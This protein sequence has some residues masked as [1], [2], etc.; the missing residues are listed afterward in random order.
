[1]EITKPTLLVDEAI[2][3]QNIRTMQAKA[4]Q[5][6]ALLRPHFKTHQSKEVGEWFRE[7]GVDAITVSS[8]SMARYFSDCGWTDIT[9][10]FPHNPLEWSEIHDLAGSIR[11]NVTIVS[12]EALDH[13]KA[14]VKNPLH[15]WIKI[16]VG[17]HRT[18]VLPENVELVR[19]LAGSGGQHQ[20]EG[21]LA[22]A[23]HSYTQLDRE[24]A[25]SIFKSSIDLMSSLKAGLGVETKLSYGDTPTCSL[26]HDFS[27]VDELRPGNFA[28]YDTMQHAFGVCTLDQIAVCLVCPVVAVHSERNE[29][30]IYGGGVHLSKDAIARPEAKFGIVVPFDGKTWSA[31][32]IGGL[33]KLSQEHGIFRRID[34]DFKIKVGDL[35][36]VLP[37]HSC[38]TADLQGYYLS[39]SGQKLTK[40]QRPQ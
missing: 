3:R 10:A 11:L 21:L 28:F 17:T 33:V 5:S 1:M 14:K 13:L 23:G 4:T 19:E 18:G 27:G 39:L 32:P 37:V 8:V 26:L 20:F 6:G 9:I 36:G 34:P 2:C 15:Y 29:V 7:E 35:V 25:Q 16:D 24:K 31:S 30:V 22:H 40:L 38:L 12:A